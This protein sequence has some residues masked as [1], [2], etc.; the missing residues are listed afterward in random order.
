MA[1]GSCW[2]AAAKEERRA[3]DS[4]A[5]LF[6]VRFGAMWVVARDARSVW[7]IARGVLGCCWVADGS[8]TGDGF[9][10]DG[11]STA[12]RGGVAMMLGRYVE[13][14]GGC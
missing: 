9:T 10:V 3:R 5:G 6:A 4:G 13:C 12:R 8:F 11:E 7:R 14:L 1:S 2:P